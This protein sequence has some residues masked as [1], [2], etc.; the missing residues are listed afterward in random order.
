MR[1]GVAA[2]APNTNDLDYGPLGVVLKHLK[3]HHDDSLTSPNC[4]S[5]KFPN[6]L[7]FVN[8]LKAEADR[9]PQRV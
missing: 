9:G 3:V 7:S 8:R 6:N 1:D 5:Q 2:R 4:K